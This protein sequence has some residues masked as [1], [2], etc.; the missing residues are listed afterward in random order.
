M[1]GHL[2]GTVA[3][4]LAIVDGMPEPRS[5]ARKRM[6]V[7]DASGG[8]AGERCVQVGSAALPHRTKT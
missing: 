5:P 4:A 1:A 2:P 3:E 7:R 6:T 8:A